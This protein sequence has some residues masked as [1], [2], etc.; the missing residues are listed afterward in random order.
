MQLKVTFDINSKGCEQLQRKSYGFTFGWVSR[1]VTIYIFMFA[2]IPKEKLVIE[3]IRRFIHYIK[4][5]KK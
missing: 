4:K 1:H 2:C 5:K 3:I